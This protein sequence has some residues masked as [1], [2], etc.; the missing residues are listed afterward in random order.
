MAHN[1]AAV[2]CRARCGAKMR[3]MMLDLVLLR[4]RHSGS[5]HSGDHGLEPA[6]AAHD[7]ARKTLRTGQSVHPHE[8]VVI[9]AAAAV[10]GRLVERCLREGDGMVA[11]VAEENNHRYSVRERDVPAI[12]VGA[13]AVVADG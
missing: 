4:W 1:A 12:A 11:D 13:V 8:L 3:L 10:E 9:A 5:G 6:A 2:V 7:R